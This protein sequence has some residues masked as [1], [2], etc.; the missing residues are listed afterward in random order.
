MIKRR[1]PFE[2]ANHLHSLKRYTSDDP[3]DL[4]GMS[5]YDTAAHGMQTDAMGM[6]RHGNVMLW[7]Q[8]D[9]GGFGNDDLLLIADGKS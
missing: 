6:N 5:Y 1:L 4:V 8:L 9:Y 2:A 3:H 7:L